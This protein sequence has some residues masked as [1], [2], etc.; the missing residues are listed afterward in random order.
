[1][2]KER[3]NYW[4]DVLL[5]LCLIVV[6]VTGLVL[7]FGF[8]SAE[9]GVG[10]STLFLGT[11]KAVWIPWHNYFGL[12]MIVLMLLHLVLHFGWLTAMTKSLFR[13]DE[14]LEKKV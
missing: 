9:P 3:L 8:V 14:I 1:M 10:R 2:V 11:S 5:V 13:K 4:V 7:Y 6:S 12:A